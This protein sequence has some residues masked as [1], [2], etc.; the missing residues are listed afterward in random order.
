[1]NARPAGRPAVNPWIIAVVVALASFMEVLDTTIANV[2]LNYISGG[3]GVSQDEAS[4]VVT[5]YLVANAVIVTATSYMV[6]VLGRKTFFLGC[7][8]LFTVSS[9]LCGFAPNLQVLLIARVLQGIGGGGMV[10]VAQ[11]IL[12]DSFPP[13]KRGQGF[14]LFGVAV[15]VAPV[16]GPTLG[17]WLSDNFSWHWC[18]LI[19]GPVGALTLFAVAMLIRDPEGSADERAKARK[20][21][22]GFD[23]IGFGLVAT[24]LGTLEL[25]LDRGLEDDWF[26]SDFIIIASVICVL[27]FALTIPW[28]L[29]HKNPAVDVRM[30]ASRQ[31]GACFLV[32]MA[33]GALLL[34][35]TQY[36]PQFVQE[37][38][39][40]TATWAGLMLSPG[41]MVTMS[42][43]FVV[44][45][46]SSRVQPKYLIAAGAGFVA[47][48]MYLV[49]KA[50]GD[51]G[52]WYLA[53]AR[54]VQGLGLPLIFLPI[55]SASYYGLPPSKTDQASALLNAARN[56]GGSIGVSLI[57]NII[58]HHEQTHQSRLIEHVIPSSQAYQQTLSQVTNYFMGQGSSQGTAQQQ[59]LA[60]IN[61]QVQSQASFLAYMDA[62]WVL[63]L[64]SLCAIPL[65]L[66]LRNVKL[67]GKVSMGH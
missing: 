2:A 64:I 7:L 65:A 61:N 14:A 3:L 49:T 12:A 62:F 45:M 38:L 63:T 34:A 16:V 46:L 15:V 26:A 29:K 19:N 47:L 54:M 30:L 43:M 50:Y 53:K 6:R 28:E 60:W 25:V 55:T 5:T 59:A 23:W 18:F 35:T 8:A 24:F 56:T 4:W 10:P 42:M 51:T 11:S 31:F 21:H 33:T 17:G 48:A 57:S 9:V 36:L 39:G 66:T 52:F 41:G 22:G 20:E 40:Y 67:G 44:G 32:M 1:M 13:E 37:N 27:A 58:S